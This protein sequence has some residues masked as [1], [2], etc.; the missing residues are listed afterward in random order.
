MTALSLDLPTFAAIRTLAMP[1]DANPN[2]DIFGGWLMSQMDIAGGIT[3][4]MRARGRVVTVAVK[5]MEFHVP[6]AVGGIVSCYAH[7]QSVGTSSITILVEVW[8]LRQR[9]IR[10][11]IKATAGIFTYVAI[12]GDGNKRPVPPE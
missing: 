1:A 9:D 3:A 8:V 5:G 4:E 6:V 12:D 10:N 7:I 11:P 2:G